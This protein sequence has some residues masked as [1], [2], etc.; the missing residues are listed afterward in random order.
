MQEIGVDERFDAF[1]SSH[2]EPGA[3]E[4]VA[5]YGAI[6]ESGADER[7]AELAIFPAPGDILRD[8][9]RVLRDRARRIR[10]CSDCRLER[11]ARAS[12][13]AASMS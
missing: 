1:A 11:A 9:G 13:P 12:L 10:S 7:T 8:H 5:K 6:D 3:R 4:A 2:I